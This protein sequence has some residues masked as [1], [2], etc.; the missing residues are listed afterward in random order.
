MGSFSLL[1]VDQKSGLKN[2][3][4]IDIKFNILIKQSISVIVAVKNF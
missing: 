3:L 1:D 2:Q 4:V